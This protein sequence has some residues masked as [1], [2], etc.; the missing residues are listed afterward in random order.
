MSVCECG[1]DME[2]REVMVD[3]EGDLTEDVHHGFFCERLK[4]LR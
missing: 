2:C 4:F 3:E 1:D